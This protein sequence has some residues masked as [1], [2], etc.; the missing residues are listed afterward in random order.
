M[1]LSLPQ[2]VNAIPG[3]WMRMSASG[4]A[5]DLPAPFDSVCEGSSWNLSPGL[6][7]YKAP[8]MP[9]PSLMEGESRCD[10]YSIQHP[11]ASWIFI[12]KS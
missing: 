2:Q 9:L 3:L 6:A 11:T 7:D 1:Q 5:S 4:R 8:S 12:L 10:P